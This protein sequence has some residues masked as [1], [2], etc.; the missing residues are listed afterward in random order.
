[1]VSEEYIKDLVKCC[2]CFEVPRS[3]LH[4]CSSGHII[5]CICRPKLGKCPLC[6]VKLSDSRN[7]AVERILD[8]IPLNCKFNS[9]G[10]K[11]EFLKNLLLEHEKKCPHRVIQCPDLACKKTITSTNLV[12]HI[13]SDHKNFRSVCGGEF[14]GNILPVPAELW[15]KMEMEKN[16]L[17]AYYIKFI[18]DDQHFFFEGQKCENGEWIFWIFLHLESSE[19][20]MEDDYV[21]DVSFVKLPDISNICVSSRF[22]PLSL[23]L[24]MKEVKATGE[25]L[26]LDPTVA[27]NFMTLDHR[28]VI[29]IEKVSL[30]R[31]RRRS[32]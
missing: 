13:T 17:I 9:N 32:I 3:Y 26:T 20:S 30:K 14:S 22:R 28:L 4:Q 7:L 8:A 6:Q 23:D 24:S 2:V 1:M 19:R 11:E 18:F 31:K 5:C 12:N 25:F 27:K 29:K 10:C 16:L 21:C 15:K